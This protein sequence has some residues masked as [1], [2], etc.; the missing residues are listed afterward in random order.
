MENV[1]TQSLFDSDTHWK[2][3]PLLAFKSFIQT[4]EFL[5]MGRITK[6]NYDAEERLKPMLPSS[7]NVYSHMFGRFVEW[8]EKRNMTIFSISEIEIKDFLEDAKIENGE[9]VKTLKSSIRIRYLRLLEKVFTHLKVHPNPAKHAA[10]AIYKE[11]LGG[12][13]KIKIALTESQQNQF[14]R[15]L[16]SDDGNSEN[17]KN[18]RDRATLAMLLGAGLKVSELISLYVGDLGNMDS[19]GSIPVTVKPRPKKNSQHVGAGKIVSPLNLTG[20]EHRTLLRTFA[21]KEVLH[22]KEQRKALNI[23]GEYLFPST[24]KGRMMDKSTVYLLTKE[25]YKKAGISVSRKGPRTL[26]NSFAVRELG[27]N[28]N[29]IELTG[30]LLG[31]RER[32]STEKYLINSAKSGS[33]LSHF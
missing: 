9:V 22:W 33:K 29:A 30:Q 5:K 13:D 28:E 14:M 32:K 19:T 17:W 24:L 31:L 1:E 27:T 16:A 23:P 18:L 20:I 21:T 8:M 12:K 11:N 10:F 4:E 15:C 26:R 3:N 7:L 2:S 25:T 6:K